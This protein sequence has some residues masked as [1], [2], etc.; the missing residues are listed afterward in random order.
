MSAHA[1]TGCDAITLG[2]NFTNGGTSSETR[3][4]YSFDAGD[5]VTITGSTN[6]YGT[7][8]YDFTMAGQNHRAASATSVSHTF[9]I[10][11]TGSTSIVL[12]TYQADGLTPLLAGGARFTFTCVAAASSSSGGSSSTPSSSA[13]VEKAKAVQ[14]AVSQTQTLV[15]SNNLGTRIANIAS[16]IGISRGTPSGVGRDTTK[17]VS[18]SM[19]GG[20]SQ[21]VAD[22]S[23]SN[24]TPSNTL[25]YQLISPLVA[26]ES[27]SFDD[28][29]NAFLRSYALGASFDTST[30]ALGIAQDDTTSAKTVLRPNMISTSPLTFW[31]SGSYS[32]IENKR[33]Q[34]G[35]DGRYNGSVWGYNF[36]A[37]YRFSD[38]L[39]AGATLGYTY[40]DLT[41]TYNSGTYK[42][43]NY[44]VTPYMVFKPTD[45]FKLSA[46][47]GYSLGSLDQT[48]DSKN[49]SSDTNSDMWYASMTAGYALL[50]QQQ[51]PFSLT[52]NLNM[53]AARKSVDGYTESNGTKVARSRSYSFQVKP[54]LEAAY[55]YEMSG[56]ILQPFV[57]VDYIRDLKDS[58]N[59][60]DSA[61]DVG[62]GLRVGNSGDG[63]SG[64]LDGQTQLGRDDYEEYSFKGILAYGFSL[65]NSGKTNR[66]QP[67]VETSLD[68]DNAHA[69]SVGVNYDIPANNLNMLMKFTHSESGSESEP[70][71]KVYLEM[72]CKI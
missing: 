22:S 9:T 19:L 4:P 23:S 18:H 41:T 66:L 48:R 65:E 70:D 69:A 40:T 17:R 49:V 71:S 54:G 34:T 30:I 60:D 12:K 1:S 11:S 45:A 25:A 57:R 62:G 6:L 26:M 68:E 63:F 43:K 32:D 31:G 67:F 64:S 7:V 8:T 14:T 36:G 61:F 38:K 3:G 27:E 59:D 44:S 13:A 28:D 72:K 46:L 52:L 15:L 2:I 16:P 58:I 29:R 5:K 24:A 56:K 33:N 50:I 51:T 20:N 55:S 37:D 21:L 35:D 10:G 42:E 39:Y 53:N 47:A